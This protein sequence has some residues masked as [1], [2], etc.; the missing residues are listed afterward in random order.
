MR[1]LLV[2]DAED[3][4]DAIVSMFA[5]H[6]QPVDHAADYE[7]ARDLVTV[8]NYDVAILDINLPDG[9]GVDLLKTMRDNGITT[10]VLMLTARLDVEDRITALDM[11][12]DD[13]LMKPFDLR[14]LEARVRALVRRQGDEK[15]GRM[16]IADLMLDP[17]GKIAEIAGTP[18]ALTR[19]EYVLL[20]VFMMNRGRVMSKDRLYEKLFAFNEEDV[21][22]NAIE[23]YVGRLRRKLEGAN[24]SIR[25]LRG[26][27]YQLQDE[28]A[29]G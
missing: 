2:E 15:S 26:L 19:R 18:I 16:V 12:A 11:G 28:S 1:V 17:A 23:L 4:A 5:R 3:V 20:E 9:S 8:Q 10:P 24:V 14:E 13:Y 7:T 29:K 25:T 27:G 22:I 6:G 21:G